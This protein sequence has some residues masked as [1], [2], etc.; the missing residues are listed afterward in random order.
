MD[1]DRCEDL[2]HSPIANHTMGADIGYRDGTS[3]NGYTYCLFLT[4]LGTKATFVYR[5]RDTKGE[6]L[7]DT[8]WMYAIEAGGFPK[9]LLCDFDK[10]IIQG[11][12]AQL[13]HLHGVRIGASPPH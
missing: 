10:L 13:L 3:P 7:C 6:T 8:F 11:A 12:E 4:C 1:S 2:A 9:Q 5:L